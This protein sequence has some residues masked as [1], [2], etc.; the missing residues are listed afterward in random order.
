MKQLECKRVECKENA[1]KIERKRS[2]IKAEHG[3]AK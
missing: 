1:R 3:N 2:K